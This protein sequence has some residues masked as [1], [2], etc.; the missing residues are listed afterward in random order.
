MGIV[1]ILLCVCVCVSYLVARRVAKGG[2][3]VNLADCM[4]N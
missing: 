3:G 4:M 2:G 1:C